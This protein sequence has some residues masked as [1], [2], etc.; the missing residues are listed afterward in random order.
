MKFRQTA[1][2]MYDR[3][4]VPLRFIAESLGATESTQTVTILAP[5]PKAAFF[6]TPQTFSEIGTWMLESTTSGV[7]P[8]GA[9]RG[10]IPDVGAGA[11]SE[12]ADPSKTKPAV[13]Y[14]DVASP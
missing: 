6:I 14:L 9:I 4:L 12:D 8:T 2:I 1:H 7:F 13:A 10:M 3:T 5:I 11:T